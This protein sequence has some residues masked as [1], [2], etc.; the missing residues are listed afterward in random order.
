MQNLADNEE[1][2]LIFETEADTLTKSLGSELRD[3][4]DVLRK[5]YHHE[6]AASNRKT[7]Q[8]HIEVERPRLSVLLCGTPKQI[9]SLIPDAEN[10]LLSR[11]MFYRMNE[12]SVFKGEEELFGCE[13]E[14]GLEAVFKKLGEEFFPFFKKLRAGGEIR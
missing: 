10:G 4:S 8:E 5:A 11:F 6:F 9:T 1:G 14:E 3:F 7:N 2:G 13:D 12:E